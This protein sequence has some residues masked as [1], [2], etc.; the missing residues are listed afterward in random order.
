MFDKKTCDLK[1]HINL[2][3]TTKTDFNK[4]PNEDEKGFIQMKQWKQG[5]NISTERRHQFWQ[6]F[7]YAKG[8]D[9]WYGVDNFRV[10]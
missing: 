2:K 9:V 10:N 5:Q 1:N 3:K 7:C 4:C 8:V 6:Q